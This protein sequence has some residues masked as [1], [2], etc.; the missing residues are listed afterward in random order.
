MKFKIK[1]I[2]ANILIFLC[3]CYLQGQDIFSVIIKGNLEEVQGL[4]E[5]N[6]DLLYEKNQNDCNLLHF[7]SYLGY[8]DITEYFIQKGVD[9]DAKTDEGETPLHYAARNEKLEIVS[10]L[11]QNGAQVDIKCIRG[12]T[13]LH[14]VS[15]ENGNVAI[16][17]LLIKNG[18]D[19]NSRDNNERTPLAFST[20]RG[21]K[22]FVKFLLENGVEV[23]MKGEEA[24]D[25]LHK[26]AIGGHKEL[27]DYMIDNGINI[28][29]KSYYG[30][31][32]LHSAASGGLVESMDKLLK[33]GMNTN[34]ECRYG[35]KPIH[36]A[37]IEGNK[38]V[39]ELLLKN[40][41][42]INTK[43]KIGKTPLDYA[44]ELEYDDIVDFLVT[45]GADNNIRSLTD[46]EGKYFNQQ[47]P[48]DTAGIF[49]PGIVS[50]EFGVHSS[51]AFI[52]DGTE[53]YWTPMDSRKGGI[54]F[55]KMENGKWI[56][57]KIAAFS[58][59]YFCSNPVL[60]PDGSKLF[61][62]SERPIEQNGKPGFGIWYVERNGV[63]WSSPKQIT[64]YIS[65]FAP[66]WQISL[67]SKSNI[68]F[69]TRGLSDIYVS[70]YLN[71]DYSEPEKLEGPI[72]TEHIDGDPFIE[73]NTEYL[74]F[75]S[76]RP[77]GFGGFDLYVAFKND[78]GI[79]EEVK[80]IGAGVNS[81][82]N[83]MWPV[84]SPDGKYLFFASNRNGT[85]DSYWIDTQII[86]DLR[87]KAVVK[88]ISYEDF[89]NAVLELEKQECY[90]TALV[91]VEENWQNYPEQEFE[92]MKELEYLYRKTEQYEKSLDLFELGHEKGYF[93]LLHPNLPK[94]APYVEYARFN[95][96][97]DQDTKLRATAIDSAEM[98][99]EIVLPENYDKT[100]IYPLFF[101]L[102]GGGSSLKKAKEHWI[103]PSEIK[104]KFIIAYVQSYIYYD[105]NTFGW[106]SYDERAREDVSRI[107]DEITSEFPLDTSAV[108]IGGMSAGG[109]AAMDFAINQIIPIKRVF[110]V[111]PG[112][113]QEFDAERVEKA[114]LSDLKVMM[115]AGENDHYIP[116][117]EEM[118]TVLQEQNIP[119]TYII[120]PG[121]GHDIPD[122]L[123]E[124]WIEAIQFFQD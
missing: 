74:V 58:S 102:H 94:C 18:A 42:D 69:S 45:R 17:K 10:L 26:A 66:G 19:I 77:D 109:T 123:S 1:I 116:R 63:T 60:S 104:T 55:T 12:R 119:Y 111:C 11:L 54:Y 37:T 70:R 21:Y 120:I 47:T 39:I 121:M 34:E 82:N 20:F 8:K 2:I 16:G 27:F 65:D 87:E 101:I 112:I 15:R 85:V 90:Y 33:S 107:Y 31:T 62:H 13:P 61:F 14:V 6:E 50:S 46:F 51:P 105:S 3:V 9:L 88:Q 100:K 5:D 124:R 53:V 25:L 95:D 22:E 23:P 114:K 84:I 118:I 113:P 52:P 48:G 83:E 76:N 56:I 71:G 41:D 40:G 91:L 36:Y 96:I 72:N 38:N 28:N 49:A 110:G 4:I 93:F 30:G 24:D 122:D 79:W 89:Y 44:K 29:S 68:Y 98:I 99:F 106:R 35:L 59:G 97:V 103:I 117:Q 67:D 92:L 7:S 75:S 115:V 64:S 57:P 32:I 80:N 43:T 78:D 108:Y 81:E 86:K 73:K